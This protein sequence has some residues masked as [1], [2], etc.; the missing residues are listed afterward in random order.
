MAK[1]VKSLKA[2]TIKHMGSILA[3]ASRDAKFMKKL[4]S[5]PAKTLKEHGFDPHKQAVAVIKSLKHKSFGA[6]PKTKKRKKR[7]PHASSAAES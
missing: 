5:A 1:A 3:K 7:D 6:A 4:M 2:V